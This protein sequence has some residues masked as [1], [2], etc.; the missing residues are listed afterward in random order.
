M[1]RNH[2]SPRLT[3]AG[4]P[5]EHAGARTQLIERVRWLAIQHARV[6]HRAEHPED[7]NAPDETRGD[8]RALFLRPAE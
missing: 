4:A 1:T 6:D 5:A 8:L 7:D 2:Q 3:F